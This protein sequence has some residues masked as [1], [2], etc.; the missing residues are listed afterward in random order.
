LKKKIILI[1][2]GFYPEIGGAENSLR[3][4]ATFYSKKNYLVTVVASDRTNN[5]IKLPLREKLFGA[6]IIRYRRL[7]F[8]GYLN[9]FLVLLS[10]KLTQETDLIVARSYILLL[11]ARI[12]GFKKVVYVI[13]GV[14]KFQDKPISDYEIRLTSRVKFAIKKIIQANGFKMAYKNY[15]F[16]SNMLEQVKSVYPNAK[17]I[18][19]HPG[20]DEDRFYPSFSFSKF[21]PLHARLKL[22]PGTT[23]LLAVG[24]LQKVK[25][26]EYAI[27]A[28]SDLKRSDAILVIIGS[29]PDKMR[30]VSISSELAIKDRVFFLNEVK[31]PETYY[32][33]SNIFLFTSIYEP[34]GQVLLEAAFSGLK[35]VALTPSKDVVTATKEVF[36]GCEAL[37]AYASEPGDIARVLEKELTTSDNPATTLDYKEFRRRYSWNDFALELLK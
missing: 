22:Q 36:K 1:N 18:R 2:T 31:D 27:R 32:R 9:A 13:P 19:T 30:L 8:I 24:R 20:C 34:F 5:G 25:G 26:F 12:A 23:I 28:L 3:S 17:L 35:I 6:N 14:V 29:G 21:T 16:S 11:L 7:P 4:L 33:D 15:I 37:V 10:L